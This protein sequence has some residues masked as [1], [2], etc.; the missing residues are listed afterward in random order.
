MRRGIGR[1][2][3]YRAWRAVVET[4][5]RTAYARAWPA[6]A[7]ALFP[8]RTRVRVEHHRV[9]ALAPGCPPLRIGFAS[10][11][12]IGPTTPSRLLEEAFRQLAAA[13]CDV[14]ALGGD[15]VFLEASPEKARVLADLAARVGAPTVVAVMGNHDLWTRHDLLE[16][17][18]RAMGARVL[19]NE[20]LRLAGAHRNIA[21]VGLDDPWTG[22]RDPERAVA[23]AGDAP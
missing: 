19:V 12:H 20:A 18:L 13:R 14:L 5:L 21:L 16:A 7:W 3:H 10:D 17:S 1:G 9:E 6:R 4:T 23:A 11:L 22:E 15:F 8:G 2:R